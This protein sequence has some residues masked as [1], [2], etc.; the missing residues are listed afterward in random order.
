MKLC[1]VNAHIGH[2]PFRPLPYADA[3]TLLSEMD[4]LGIERAVVAH[5][6]GILYRNPQAANRELALAVRE[7]RDRLLPA[8]TLDPLYVDA[9]GDLRRCRDDLGMRILRLL[10]PYHGYTLAAP[11]ALAFAAA[12]RDLSMTVLV[13]FRIEDLRQRHRLDADRNTPVE[14]L[15]AFARALPGLTVVGTQFSLSADPK[16]VEA[17]QAAPGL[18]FDVTRVHSQPPY[19]QELIRAA[20]AGRFLFGTGMPLLTPEVPLVRLSLIEDEAAREAVGSGNF[21]RLFG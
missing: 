9:E 15:S 17:L 10:P 14:D 13:P 5:N 2:W 11:E 16:T 1:D 20:G 19:L 21:R 18:H 6:H 12:A 7:H 4:R 8:A 3:G